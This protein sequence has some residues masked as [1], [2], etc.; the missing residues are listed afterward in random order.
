MKQTSLEKTNIM[1]TLTHHAWNREIQRG[2][3][4]TRSAMGWGGGTGVIAR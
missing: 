3:E 1:I 2:G 4:W